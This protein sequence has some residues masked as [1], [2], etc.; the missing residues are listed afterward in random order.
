V[1]KE[2][3]INV[4]RDRDPAILETSIPGVFSAGDVRADSTKQVAS[5]AGEGATAALLIRDYHK[6][7]KDRDNN[8][9]Q[10]MRCDDILIT[11]I[12]GM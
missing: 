4:Y 7:V 5:A 12:A 1:C 10:F 3:E 8:H 11:S 6:T 2:P 9:Y